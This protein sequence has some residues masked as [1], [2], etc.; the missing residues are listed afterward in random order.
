MAESDVVDALVE[1]GFTINESRAYAALLVAG[2]STG[3]E[4]HQRAGVPRSA[5]YGS[6]RRLVSHGAARSVAGSPERFVAVAPE[7]LMVLL[8]KRHDAQQAG[9]ER[10]ISTL[11]VQPD[12]PEAFTVEGYERIMEEVERLVRTA[13]DQLV[14]SGWP[15]ELARLESEL[16]AASRRGVY[17]VLFSH[18]SLPRDLAGIHFS[19][20]RNEADLEDFWE[21]RLTIVA[22]DKRTLIGA[23]EGRASDA[24]VLSE[25]QAIA[26]V[27][28]SQIALDI[29]LLA[30]RHGH[31]VEKV[32]ARIL[33]DR[34][35]RLDTLEGKG[36]GAV[37][38]KRR[39]APKKQG[40]KA[41][42][43]EEVAS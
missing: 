7:E 17:T 34:V 18:A 35:G 40:G 29:T 41:A 30:Q 27:A 33:G 23:V 5:V 6:L 32:M 22:D 38:G 20:G 13:E 39:S 11:D 8:R 4:V 28:T 31:D 15:R 19:Y 3:Y 26:E 43:T 16:A 14:I 12:V 10:A 36:E 25:T 24:A 42:A 21:H 1:L 37:V 2:P 9:L